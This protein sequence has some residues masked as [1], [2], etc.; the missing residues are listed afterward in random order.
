MG[1]I[2]WFQ[3]A[4]RVKECIKK[5]DAGDRPK[6]NYRSSFRSQRSRFRETEVSG[7][8]LGSEY[9]IAPWV[10]KFEKY[11]SRVPRV[12]WFNSLSSPFNDSSIL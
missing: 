11:S 4:M 2:K 12:P 7:E 9:K 3:N 1:E 8:I 6:L 10:P 5:E